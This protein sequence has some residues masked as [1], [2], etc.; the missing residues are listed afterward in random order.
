MPC[1]G[2]NRGGQRRA[3][4]PSLLTPPFPGFRE[5]PAG[6]RSGGNPRER[7]NPW[8]NGQVAG[9]DGP[10][11]DPFKHLSRRAEIRFGTLVVSGCRP[12]A[13]G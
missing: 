12:E 11:H 13:S 7:G 2:F 4:S 8:E 6:A 10:P 5:S 9:R 3:I 1:A